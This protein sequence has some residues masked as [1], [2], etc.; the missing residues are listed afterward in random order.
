M[1]LE[2]GYH[3]KKSTMQQNKNANESLKPSKKSGIGYTESIS[4]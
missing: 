4:S 3:K 1:N 2:S